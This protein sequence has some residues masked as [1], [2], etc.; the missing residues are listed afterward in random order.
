MF[1]RPLVLVALAASLAALSGC[2]AAATPGDPHTPTTVNLS[3]PKLADGEKQDVKTGAV[4]SAETP[5]AEAEKAGMLGV[6]GGL[7]G[8]ETPPQSVWG[9]ILGNADVDVGA[10]FGAGGLGLSG[11]GTG[12]GGTGAGIGLGSIGTFGHGGATGFGSGGGGLGSGRSS[13]P[14]S[15]S[16]AHNDRTFVDLGDVVSHGITPER[17]VEMLRGRIAN[18]SACYE[19]GF[20]TKT[21]VAGVIKVGFSVGADGYV[22][23]VSDAGSPADFKK[24]VECLS[25]SLKRAWVEKPMNGAPAIVEVEIRLAPS[26]PK[27]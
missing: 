16:G 18:V 2:G 4:R 6:L 21:A 20:A 3:R 10:A 24:V 27:P 26:P 9:S 19:E 7:N 12:G 25:K 15:V 11:L 22:Q 13:S 17:F 8:G 1:P 23:R 14:G 5:P